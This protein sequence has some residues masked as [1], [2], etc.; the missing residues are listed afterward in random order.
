MSTEYERGIS[1]GFKMGYSKGYLDGEIEGSG[2]PIAKGVRNLAVLSPNN[3]KDMNVIDNWVQNFTA[4]KGSYAVKTVYDLSRRLCIIYR[5]GY[6]EEA[7]E[8][9]ELFS[10]KPLNH[11]RIGELLRYA[12]ELI[13]K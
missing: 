13:W 12:E 3:Q 1:D 7:L 11:T 6:K 5:D 2:Y 10:S 4:T 9:L 8:L